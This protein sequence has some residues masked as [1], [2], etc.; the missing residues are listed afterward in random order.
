VTAN[1]ADGDPDARGAARARPPVWLL[2][3]PYALMALVV[4]LTPE[5]ELATNQGDLGLYLRDGQA[6]LA[7]QVPYRDVSFEYPPL[8]LIPMLAPFLLWPF[9]T[10]TLDAYKWLFAVAWEGTLLIAIG[11]LVARIVRLGGAADGPLTG[12][13]ARTRVRNTLLR[14]WFLSAGAALVIAWRYDLFPTLLTVAAL[15][16]VLEARSATSGVALGLGVLAKLYPIV[17]GPALAIRALARRD[18]GAARRLGLVAAV[19]VAVGLLPFVLWAGA[20]ALGFLRYQGERG[21]QLESVA[22]GLIQLGGVVSGT[23]PAIA[24]RFNAVEVVDGGAASALAVLPLVT[25]VAFAVLAV[26]GWRRAGDE[27]GSSGDVGPRTVVALVLA[28]L[29]VLLATSK[30]FSIQYIVW[31]V[32]FAALLPRGQFWLA[33][34]IVWLTMPIHPLLYR[35]LVEQQALPILVLNLR[36]GL[37]VAL[38]GWILRDLARQAAAPGQLTGSS[39][40][41]VRS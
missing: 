17:L 37:L 19:V 15:A 12:P 2:A 30:V 40:A 24:T 35:W 10:M 7:G 6:V 34:A 39:P 5:R 1:P 32:P 21:L 27:A 16:A 4:L 18:L 28:S 25:V 8:S 11:L 9:G 38:L 41:G 26:I 13:A 3:V 33:A 20:D 36:N 14:L 31:I 23:P 29:L 22:A